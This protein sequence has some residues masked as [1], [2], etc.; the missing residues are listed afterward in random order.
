[1]AIETL[2]AALR[3][4]NRLFAEGV[5]AG[6]TDAQLLDRFLAQ[7]D[8]GAFE[9]LVARH[10]PMVLSVC[11]G[12]LRDPRD[13]E[14]AFQATF[15]VLVKKAGSIRGRDALGGW[16][17][18]VA[19]RVAIQ[20]NAAAARRRAKERQAGEMAAATSTSGPS[21][22]DELLP[23]IHEEL[24]RLPE[25]FRLA[26]VL[27][28]L[29]G[30]TQTQAAGQLHWSERT[31]RYRLVEG[32]ARLEGRLARR[33]LAPDGAMLGAVLFR[34]AQTAVP[35]AW[36]EA[37]V[38]AALDL[39]NQTITAGV[40][41]AAA[42]SLT[43]EVVKIML[44][45]KFKWASAIV[46]A[47]GAG[48][49]VA[50]TFALDSTDEPRRR[51]PSPRVI[52]SKT[53]PKREFTKT[54]E[55]DRKPVPIAGRVLDPDGKPLPS[56]KIY[57]RHNHWFD[58][59]E[60]SRAVEQPAMS[61]P[62]GRFLINLDPY[63]SDAPASDG[64]SWHEAMIAAVAP[65]Y[66]PAWIRAGEA[67]QSGAE[68]QLA[69]DDLPIRG[70][71]LDTQGRP[72]ANTTVRV[73]WLAATRDGVDRDALLASGKLDWDG[74]TT[75][76]I[77]R[78]AWAAPVWIGRD[79][80][81]T[82]DAEGRFTIN[83]LGRDRAAV[84][85]I[86]APG[87]EHARIAVLDRTP[88]DQ[89]A[90]PPRT[91]ASRPVMLY[92]DAELTLY[93]TRFE[94]VVGPTKPITGIVRLKGNG[95]PVPGVTVAG[96]I[97]GRPWTTVMTRTDEAGRYRLEGLPKADSY[98][99]DIRPE[100]GAAYLG[101]A[102][103]DITDTQGLAPIDVPFELPPAVM[104]R[105]RVL[106]KQTGR[107]VPCDWI[108]YFPFPEN[109]QQGSFHGTSS[110]TDHTFRISVP[111]GG[112]MIAVKA[113]GKSVPYP[114]ARL[115]AA[116]KGKLQI[117]GEDGSQ[118]GIP[119][120]IY[121]AYRFVDFAEG[122]ESATVDLE[123]TPGI[124]RKVELVGPTGQPVTGASAMGLTTDP[125][126]SMTIDGA[127]F[128]IQGLRPDETRLVEIRHEGLGLS[129][130]V[131]VSGSDLADRPLIVK[132]AH[133]GAISGRLLD[134]DGLPLREAKVE[135]IVVK[136]RGYGASD[137][138]FR[139][140]ASV[141]DTEG[142]FRIDGINPTLNVLL[143]YH[144]AGSPPYSHRPKPDEDLS[145][146]MVKS[147]EILDIGVVHVRFDRRSEV[148]SD[149]GFSRSFPG[150]GRHPRG[151]TTGDLLGLVRR[152]GIGI[153]LLLRAERLGGAAHV[154][155]PHWLWMRVCDRRHRGGD[156]RPRPG[157][158]A[159]VGQGT[160]SGRRDG[161]RRGGRS[162]RARVVGGSLDPPQPDGCLVFPAAS[163]RRPPLERSHR[164]LSSTCCNG[165]GHRGG[166]D[167]GTL[168]RSR[169]PPAA[170]GDRNLPRPACDLR[171]G[172]RAADPFRPGDLL[173]IGYPPTVR[174]VAHDS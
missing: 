50:V 100:P 44:V 89:N 74:I 105:G 38:R 123:V 96:Q 32:R 97:M 118:F 12:I 5:V 159:E 90:S 151:S 8:A 49:I 157:R 6:L 106:D 40:V 52:A 155:R 165:S 136:R 132:L 11:R 77:R 111:P 93:G 13:A 120:S 139:P 135:A 121:H 142:R 156:S 146:L 22:P 174:D 78:P 26:I 152:G 18:R 82:T 25:K 113:L 102:R 133:H 24:A 98:F 125:F 56:A 35:A 103:R 110:G 88:R 16:M 59:G 23:A 101:I 115:A 33:G 112:G 75:P 107:A 31:L 66:G 1:M 10:G 104:V 64:P 128:E 95:R 63:K 70:H 109:R 4:I 28:D 122:T 137:P 172:A 130:S 117:K 19:Y 150:I 160:R 116:D 43:R 54:A 27:C 53:E 154:S 91:R 60:A 79:G 99:L 171:V 9:A 94:H 80:A 65:G 76:T 61:G 124:S 20:A 7:K 62:D 108:V 84:L 71:I 158:Q 166:D 39:I 29:E 42:G 92:Q 138:I 83:G 73:E 21:V 163:I 86:E 140:R 3:Q 134:E 164:V 127:R 41:S 2:G 15:L 55:A 161:G 72:A 51:D 169:P 17:Y 34:E 162:R 87:L 69:R 37:T 58:P 46:L 149:A 147:G 45:Q 14:D 85:R 30:M 131:S 47:V 168:D 48:G 173:G 81:V 143:W 144:K 126:A 141:T 170:N 153:G 129:G 148:R 114:G 119:L 68:L 57:V 145:N 167:R 36:S 67:A